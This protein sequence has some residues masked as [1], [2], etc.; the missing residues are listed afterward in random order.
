VHVSVT[1]EEEREIWGWVEE[2][3]VGGFRVPPGLLDEFN[4]TPL[5][6]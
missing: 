4:D 3:G 1:G 6:P 2:V 5:L